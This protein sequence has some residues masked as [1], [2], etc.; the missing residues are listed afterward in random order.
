MTVGHLFFAA[1][2][3]AYIMV[4]TWIEER[5]LVAHLGDTYRNYRKQVPAFFPIPR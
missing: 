2:T 3:T 5:D 1:M 4:G